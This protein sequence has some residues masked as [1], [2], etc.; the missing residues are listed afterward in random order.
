MPNKKKLFAK[1]NNS[2]AS[3]SVYSQQKYAS[4]ITHN[5][6]LKLNKSFD[7]V[8]TKTSAFILYIYLDMMIVKDLWFTSKHFNYTFHSRANV[9][10]VLNCI[11][12][13][14][15]LMFFDENL[16]GKYLRNVWV[17]NFIKFISWNKTLTV[18][19]YRIS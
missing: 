16:H 1:L 9:H 17:D 10:L 5:H 13:V 12:I 15:N 11:P 18:T 19:D 2:L 3:K 7:Q 6:T 14:V 8:K 4:V